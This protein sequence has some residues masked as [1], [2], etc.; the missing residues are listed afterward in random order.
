MKFKDKNT[1]KFVTAEPTTKTLLYK[2]Y[3]HIESDEYFAYIKNIDGI[4]NGQYY[5]TLLFED[6]EGTI[7]EYKNL[8]KSEKHLSVCVEPW[9]DQFRTSIHYLHGDIVNIF[10]ITGYFIDFSDHKEIRNVSQI[11]ELN[12]FELEVYKRLYNITNMKYT[13]KDCEL[14]SAL[15]I[16]T[17]EDP[18]DK[19]TFDYPEFK[20]LTNKVSNIFRSLHKDVHLV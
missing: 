16:G 18:D 9:G 12:L 3:K 15:Y 14:L 10:Q 17:F 13:K 5:F 7:Y 2:G 1:N 19:H 4:L 6:N 8:Q 11:T 20:K